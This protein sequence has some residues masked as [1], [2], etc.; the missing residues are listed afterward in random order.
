V[1]ASSFIEFA[2]PGERTPVG[3]RLADPP[4]NIPSNWVMCKTARRFQ[5]TFSDMSDMLRTQKGC[6]ETYQTQKVV[7]RKD[8]TAVDGEW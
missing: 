8:G 5:A 6:N 3:V 2:C 1:N 7:E 4:A